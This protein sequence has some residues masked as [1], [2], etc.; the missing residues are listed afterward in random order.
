MSRLKANV[1]SRRLAVLVTASVLGIGGAGIAMARQGGGMGN[2]GGMNSGS[3]MGSGAQDRTRDR[4]QDRDQ[5]QDR[6]RD[7]DQLRD[8]I[9]QAPGGSQRQQ[10]MNQYRQQIDAGMQTMQRR[11]AQG[12]GPNADPD[13]RYRY[14]QQN[15]EQM[16]RM[17]Q[18]M[19]EYQQMQ[20]GAQ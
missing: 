8:R 14:M 7:M 18:H 17:M 4:T 19:W 15:Q 11:Q 3:G 16:E 10:L 1:W 13:A 20:R 6:L 5:I 2:G 9:H 12:P